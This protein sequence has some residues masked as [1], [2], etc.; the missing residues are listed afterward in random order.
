M[1]LLEGTK[2]TTANQLTQFYDKKVKTKSPYRGFCY[3]NY[4]RDKELKG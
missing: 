2:L 1:Y 3:A 4:L